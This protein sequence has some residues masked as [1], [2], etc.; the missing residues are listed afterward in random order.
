MAHD[1]LIIYHTLDTHIQRTR[2]QQANILVETRTGQGVQPEEAFAALT[3]HGIEVEAGG[4]VAAH[5]TDP[6]GIA[7]ELLRSDH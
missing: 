1:T 3:R 4:L 6:R 5:A 2:S 7:V